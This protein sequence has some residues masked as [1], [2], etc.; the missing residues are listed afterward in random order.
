MESNSFELNTDWLVIL[1]LAEGC[2]NLAVTAVN[3]GLS[4]GTKPELSPQPHTRIPG[5]D[6]GWWWAP[7]SPPLNPTKPAAPIHLIKDVKNNAAEN[8]DDYIKLGFSLIGTNDSPHPSGVICLLLLLL[9]G[10]AACGTFPN[11]G[12]NPCPLHWQADSKPLIQQ[13]SPT[14]GLSCGFQL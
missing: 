8:S 5:V 14:L 10:H 1:G 7:C 12:W 2:R 3:W 11:Q 6:H 13:G 4:S 9:F